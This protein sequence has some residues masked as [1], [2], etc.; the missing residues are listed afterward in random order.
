MI[1]TFFCLDANESN[2]RKNQGRHDRSAH[3][4]GPAPPPV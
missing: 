1:V 3:P 2:Q 4:S